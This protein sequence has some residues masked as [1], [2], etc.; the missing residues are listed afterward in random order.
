MGHGVVEE[1]LGAGLG[2]T[3]GSLGGSW[4]GLGGSWGSIWELFGGSAV[5]QG[6]PLAIYRHVQKSIG[7]SM[8][9][10]GFG[11]SQ[12]GLWS[13]LGGLEGGLGCCAGLLSG[14][15]RVLWGLG[16]SGEVWGRS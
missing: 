11:V 4:G 8:V 10:E 9:F 2:A 13:V 14:H 5:A 3:W 12:Q 16:G 1:D 15:R 7:F 6:R